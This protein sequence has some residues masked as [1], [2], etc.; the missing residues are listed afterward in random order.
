MTKR[1]KRAAKAGRRGSNGG[2]PRRVRQREQQ[3]LV[4]VVTED[5]KTEPKY[6]EWLNKR[7]TGVKITAKH[8]EP[9]P[10]DVVALAI[11]ERDK[12]PAAARADGDQGDTYDDV[13]C[14]VDVDEHPGLDRALA[15]ARK[16]GLSVAVS[17]L[18]F[19]TWLLMHLSDQTRPYEK[20]SRE[21]KAWD[22]A[23]GGKGL[24]AIS[25]GLERALQRFAS[26]R[27]RHALDGRDRKG[28]PSTEVDLFIHAVAKLARVPPSKLYDMT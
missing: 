3:K 10:P 28:N 25:Q 9:N 23:T 2:A 6:L 16:A 7:V 19:E 8:D 11:R 18:C 26:Q 27:R 21:K 5:E 22:A 14:F 15:T 20:S 12:G 13:W 4:L 17:S 1:E 24:D